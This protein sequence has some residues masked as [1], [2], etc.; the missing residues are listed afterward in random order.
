MILEL[1][2]VKMNWHTFDSEGI[3]MME[4]NSAKKK[5]NLVLFS[6]EVMI[7]LWTLI[8]KRGKVVCRNRT[9]AIFDIAVGAQ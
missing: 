3:F 5:E 7:L 4:I 8:N 9:R 2:Y 1:F 6:L